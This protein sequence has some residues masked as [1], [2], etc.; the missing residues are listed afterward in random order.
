MNRTRM[1]LKEMNGL[2]EVSNHT[3]KTRDMVKIE[4]GN[5]LEHETLKFLI[6]YIMKEKS[7]KFLTECRFIQGGRADC[8]CLT[9]QY[10]YEILMSE[11]ESNIEEKK[12]IY[13]NYYIVK[14]FAKNYM[15]ELKG[16][17]KIYEKLKDIVY[18]C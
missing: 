12:K 8:F 11:K 15:K 7:Q 9:T 14:I 5:K 3:K 13:P 10:I 16:I 17:N 6:C 2:R 18:D 1:I 4:K